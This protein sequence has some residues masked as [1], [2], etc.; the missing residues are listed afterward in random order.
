MFANLIWLCV[1][2]EEPVKP[3]ENLVKEAE[4]AVTTAIAEAK[5]V[6]P[7]VSIL[8]EEEKNDLN[9]KTEWRNMWVIR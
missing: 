6:Q 2:T 4:V 3:E 8:D 1:C 9:L 7:E 5:V